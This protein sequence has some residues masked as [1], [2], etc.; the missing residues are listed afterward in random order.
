M[1]ASCVPGEGRTAA[2][3]SE[4]LFPLL[5]L[6]VVNAAAR[7]QTVS[8]VGRPDNSGARIVDAHASDLRR[9]ADA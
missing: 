2:D 7:V 3:V 5:P 8:S 4:T 9:L 1:D 6:A